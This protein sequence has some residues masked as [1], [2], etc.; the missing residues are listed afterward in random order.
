MKSEDL[1][2]KVAC[3]AMLKNS[4]KETSVNYSDA[5]KELLIKM[6][7]DFISLKFDVDKLL[8][9]HGVAAGSGKE[10]IVRSAAKHFKKAYQS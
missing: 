3:E 4:S 10:K 2:F 9:Q 1:N 5:S 7:E 8:E 6:M